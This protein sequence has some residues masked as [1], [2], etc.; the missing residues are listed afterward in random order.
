MRGR[1]NARRWWVLGLSVCAAFLAASIALDTT[2]HRQ[3]D[4]AADGPLL[5]ERRRGRGRGPRRR[6]PGGDA[7]G[8]G[9][10]AAARERY[11]ATDAWRADHEAFCPEAA[12]TARETRSIQAAGLTQSPLATT[13]ADG[14]WGPLLHIPTNAIHAALMHTGKV[15]WF[16]RPRYPTEQDA[17]DGGNAHVWDPATGTSR[18]VPPP[19]LSYPSAALAAAA[20]PARP[21]SG[22]PGRPSSRTAACWWSAATWSTPRTPAPG[23]ATGP[24]T[25][26][27]APPG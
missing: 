22:A 5:P 11:C 13:E 2:G 6:P 14:S 24:A 12:P 23:A 25:A 19:S 17:I 18:S 10:R 9:A 26:S 7:G 15:L 21:T 8:H 4:R 16:S 27:R 1:G 20:P 3:P